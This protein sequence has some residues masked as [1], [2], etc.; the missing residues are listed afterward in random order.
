[1]SNDLFSQVT[2]LG[3]LHHDA[4]SARSLVKEGI[5]VRNHVLITATKKESSIQ[6]ISFCWRKIYLPYGGENADLVQSVLLFL[7]RQS[8]DFDLRAIPTMR[9]MDKF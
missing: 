6:Y 5:L 7:L 9:P 2:A 1:M 8:L 3:K 4:E